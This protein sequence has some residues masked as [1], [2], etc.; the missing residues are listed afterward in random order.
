MDQP[1]KFGMP[2]SE[3]DNLTAFIDKYNSLSPYI[4]TENKRREIMLK[5]NILTGAYYN[6]TTRIY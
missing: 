4:S 1:L 3:N 2:I 5:E 6:E